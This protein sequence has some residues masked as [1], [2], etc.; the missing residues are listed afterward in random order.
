GPAW[1]AAR[2]SSDL[3]ED[4]SERLQRMVENEPTVLIPMLKDGTV[5]GA[6][7]DGEFVPVA[8][9]GT[10]VP[11][12]VAVPRSR[13]GSGK[14]PGVASSP[15]DAVAAAMDLY[16]GTADPDS[17]YRLPPPDML[18]LG[19]PAKLRSKANDVVVASL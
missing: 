17:N 3:V 4:R 7:I 13:K 2:G 15:K 5:A 1:S 16:A 12:P 11:I 18:R 14:K 9:D 19:A 8:D 10:S 6:D